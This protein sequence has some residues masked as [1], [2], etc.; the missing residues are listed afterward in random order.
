MLHQL[1]VFNN[2]RNMNRSQIF[3]EL[4]AEFKN[5]FYLQGR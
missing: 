1:K 2:M 4:R 3:G 5:V